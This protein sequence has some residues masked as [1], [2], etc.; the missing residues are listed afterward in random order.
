MNLLEK[1]ILFY[2]EAAKL[3]KETGISHEVDHIIPLQGEFVS[4]LHV[5]NNLQIIPR[6]K[7]RSRKNKIE[8]IL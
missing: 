4:D 8:G 2:I 6:S 5:H 7:N 3:T 1:I